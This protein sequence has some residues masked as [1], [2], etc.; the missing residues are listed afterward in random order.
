M[1]CIDENLYHKISQVLFMVRGIEKK[2]IYENKWQPFISASRAQ[3]V[4]QTFANSCEF[5]DIFLFFVSK[6][7]NDVNLYE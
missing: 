3:F 2:K 6:V 7:W 1:M 5:S 4:Y